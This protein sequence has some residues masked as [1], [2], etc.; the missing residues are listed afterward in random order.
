MKKTKE[1]KAENT[2]S[3]RI[4]AREYSR[5]YTSGIEFTNISSKQ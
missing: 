3:G 1:R 2:A 4:T 5:I